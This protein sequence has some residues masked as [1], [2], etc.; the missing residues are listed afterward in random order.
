MN[1]E[2]ITF[3]GAL[4]H[5]LAARFDRPD[6]GRVR[7]CAL[8]AHCFTCGKDLKAVTRLS[9]ALTARGIAVLR[10]DFT[11]LGESAGD[12]A[13]TNFS[14]NV[15]DL[16]AAV[17]HLRA[18]HGAPQVLIGHSLGGAA[19]LQAAGQVDTCRAVVTI[20][21]PSDTEHLVDTI[22]GGAEPA[23]DD[24]DSARVELA[25]RPF[26]IRRQLVDDLQSQRVLD[27]VGTLDRPLLVLHSPVDTIVGIDHARRIYEAAKHPKSFVSLDRADH[28]LL[29][30]PADAR[31]VAEVVAAWA[32]RYVEL[33]DTDEPTADAAGPSLE[34]GEVE[35]VGGASG[36]V[37]QVRTDGH[38]LVA[39][40]PKRVGGTDTGPTPYDFLLA[41]LGTCTN[42]TLR[43]YAD[44]KEWPLGGVVTCLRHSK[45][46]GKDCEECE[47]Q[48]AKVDVI[49]RTIEILGDDL[50]EAQLARLMEIADRCPVHRTLTSETIIRSEKV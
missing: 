8:F 9:R 6:D 28:L 40:E 50:D 1:S 15:D 43:M 45:V 44:R 21:A 47:T 41:A 31:Y 46:H 25:G 29:S 39:D 11:G 23:F 10:F 2:T 22:F 3:E 17:D 42:M 19:V 37:Q 13:D 32:G 5:P 34:H 20:A 26:R 14:S 35:V 16:L 27:A 33:A 7:A 48:N 18:T 24:D 30:D 38:V 4:G 36:F 49:D 12:F